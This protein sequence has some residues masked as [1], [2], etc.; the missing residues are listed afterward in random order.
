MSE[1][2]TREKH[3]YGRQKGCGKSWDGENSE[4]QKQ[5]IGHAAGDKQ[6]IA[7]RWRGGEV[8]KLGVLLKRSVS[9]DGKDSQGHKEGNIWQ[10]VKVHARRFKNLMT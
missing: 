6:C 9:T 3:T 5:K 4:K 7:G 8:V 1:K 2:K 10:P